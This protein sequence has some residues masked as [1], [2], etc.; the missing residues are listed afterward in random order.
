MKNKGTAVVAT[1]PVCIMNITLYV[2]IL[3]DLHS[4]TSRESR[5]D[6]NSNAGGVNNGATLDRKYKQFPFA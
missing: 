6:A 3:R 4:G 5:L 1:L 2:D